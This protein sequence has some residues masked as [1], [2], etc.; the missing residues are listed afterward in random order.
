MQKKEYFHG[1]N[2]YV[3]SL[4]SKSNNIYYKEGYEQAKGF[5][6]IHNKKPLPRKYQSKINLFFTE[7]LLEWIMNVIYMI[8]F[9]FVFPFYYF[10]LKKDVENN[11]Y[12]LLKRDKKDKKSTK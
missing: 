7:T 11:T 8:V 6:K 5:E 1:W 10:I 2:D 9:A 4:E 3:N 12:P